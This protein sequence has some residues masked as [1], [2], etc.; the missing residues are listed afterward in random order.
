MVNDDDANTGLSGRTK[1]KRSK[2]GGELYDAFAG[3]SDEELL[4]DEEE[5][6]EEYRDKGP[7]DDLEDPSRRSSQDEYNEK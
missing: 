6:Q 1:G 2:R 5:E 3:E 4:S 7:R